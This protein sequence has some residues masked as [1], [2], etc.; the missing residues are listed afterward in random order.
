MPNHI[1]VNLLFTTLYVLNDESG[2]YQ[3]VE[4][5]EQFSIVMV[6]RN[7]MFGSIYSQYD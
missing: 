7:Q 1:K 6:V 3:K 5:Q 2:K 4:C